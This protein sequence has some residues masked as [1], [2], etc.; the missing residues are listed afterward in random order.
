MGR[1]PDVDPE[2][3]RG[4]LTDSDDPPT[5]TEVADAL[6]ERLGR[7]V[8]AALVRQAIRRHP[9]WGLAPREDGRPT[10]VRYRVDQ[11]LAPTSMHRRTSHDLKRMRAWERWLRGLLEM[12]STWM[13][14]VET[15]VITRLES[16]RV[17]DYDDET[18]F[19]LRLCFPWEIGYYY[20]QPV[21]GTA[22]VLLREF[23]GR[24]TTTVMTVT[25]G[26]DEEYIDI[27]VKITQEHIDFW[28]EMFKRW[29]LR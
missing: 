4:I 3:I 10:A 16:G 24:G 12:D 27:D 8:S 2:T 23:A 28:D 17:T 6:T 29:P 13:R 19:F 20:R 1:P 21:P 5:S 18:G 11:A 25:P 9:E 7:D 22:R 14:S 26:R 15:Y